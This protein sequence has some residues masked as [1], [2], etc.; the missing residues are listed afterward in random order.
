[1]FIGE[2]SVAQLLEDLEGER[3]SAKRFQC[4]PGV[5]S[6]AA[7][8]PPSTAIKTPATILVTKSDRCLMIVPFFAQF[9]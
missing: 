7:Q 2:A 6:P 3:P 1:M 9:F 4:L 5:S 8:A